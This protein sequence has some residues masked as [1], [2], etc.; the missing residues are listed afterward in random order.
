MSNTKLAFTWADLLLVLVL[1]TIGAGVCALS[2]RVAEKAMAPRA[3]REAAF[4][5][6]AGVLR[7]EQALSVAGDER[8]AIAAQLRELGFRQMRDSVALVLADSDVVMLQAAKPPASRG[9]IDSLG[10]ER[11]RLRRSLRVDAALAVRLRAAAARMGDSVAS[12]RRAVA[13]ARKDG[14]R[15][16]RAAQRRFALER[17]GWTAGVALAGTSLLL[18]ITAFALRPR[19]GRTR[20][21]RRGRVIGISAGITTLFLAHQVLGAPLTLL[22]GALIALILLLPM[23]QHAE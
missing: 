10:R 16:Y 7:L 9:A 19:P 18:G 2:A 23:V 22:M 4:Q 21:V 8:N 14:G 11:T 13:T 12:S 17:T 20:P 6:S 15:S 5:D 3:P 1:S